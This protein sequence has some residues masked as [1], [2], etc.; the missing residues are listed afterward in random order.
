MKK[1][2]VLLAALA[3]AGCQDARADWL[4]FSYF[5]SIGTMAYSGQTFDAHGSAIFTMPTP[6]YQETIGIEAD[7]FDNHIFAGFSE[8][9]WMHPEGTFTFTPDENF[10]SISAGLRGWG[11][12]IGYRHE[13]DHPIVS[14]FGDIAPH[15]GFI[16]NTDTFYLSYTG[17]LKV[18]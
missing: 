1:L 13:C 4:A 16:G 14:W 2:I 18:F 12:E 11:F 8:E 7:A 10:Y 15:Q 3:L 17:H 9:T 5:V 6:S